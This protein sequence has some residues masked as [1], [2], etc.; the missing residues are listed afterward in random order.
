MSK[1]PRSWGGM[2]GGSIK[3]AKN[4]KKIVTSALI[5]I[6]GGFFYFQNTNLT[7]AHYSQDYSFSGNRENKS[8]DLNLIKAEASGNMNDTRA[9]FENS[10]TSPL[11][12]LASP[13]NSQN[14]KNQLENLVGGAP[15][16]E[17]VPEIAKQDIRVAAYLIGIAKKESSWGSASPEK[18]G[19]DCYNYWGYKGSGSRGTGMGY[20]CFGSPKEAVKTVGGRIS[21]LLNKNINTPSQMVVWKCGSS[22]SGQ[23]PGDVQKWISDVSLYYDK[24]MDFG[25]NS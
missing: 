19:K 10:K 5:I 7:L 24:V 8:A 18:D 11:F 6:L 16:G 9:V 4:K 12:S 17:M 25:K 20:S 14:F 22:C 15:I 2:L 21:D 13:D 3:K 23:D 1:S